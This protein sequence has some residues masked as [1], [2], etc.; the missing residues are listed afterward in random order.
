MSITDERPPSNTTASASDLFYGP[1]LVSTQTADLLDELMTA[2]A[3]SVKTMP[4]VIKRQ[5]MCKVKT[6]YT[7]EEIAELADRSPTTVRRWIAEGDL[8][9]IRV[10]GTGPREVL[11]IPGTEVV[12][13]FLGGLGV[14]VPPE[15]IDQLNPEA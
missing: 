5:I 14:Y 7:I 11:N 6:F 15:K 1:N 12:K 3:E 9:A 4:K 13:L 10:P 2:A 8:E